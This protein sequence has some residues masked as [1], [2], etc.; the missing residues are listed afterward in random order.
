MLLSRN[1]GVT[2]DRIDHAEVLQSEVS[3]AVRG[4]GVIRRDRTAGDGTDRGLAVVIG[5]IF[6]DTALEHRS[7]TVFHGSIGALPD[8]GVIPPQIRV[9]DGIAVDAVAVERSCTGRPVDLRRSG[10][11]REGGA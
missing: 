9:D 11:R 5:L 3:V 2:F 10:R 4:G 1:R 7:I 6:I 8:R